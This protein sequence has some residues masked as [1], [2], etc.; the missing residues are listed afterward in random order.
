ME[1]RDFKGIEHRE[2]RFPDRGILV[3]EGPNEVG[4]TSMIEALDLLLDHKDTSRRAEI[5]AARPIGRDVGPFVEVEMSTGPYRFTYRKRWLRRSLTELDVTAPTREQ[6]VG[7]VAHERVRALLAQTADLHLWRALRLMQASP[8]D[9]AELSGSPALAAALDRAAG[10]A[11]APGGEGDTILAAA[12]EVYLRYFT[13]KSGQPTGEYRVLGERLERA[14]AAVAA[15]QAGLDEVAADVDRHARLQAEITECARQETAA[16]AALDQVEA[17]WADVEDVVA[18]A[19]RARRAHDDARRDHDLAI[20]RAQERARAVRDLAER[21]LA[22]AGARSTLDE[23]RERLAPDDAAAAGRAAELDAAVAAEARTRADLV[24]A[25]A[26]AE[27]A[28]EAEELREVEA[29]L[30][31]IDRA[32][33]DLHAA[34]AAAD[35]APVDAAALRRVEDAAR[36]LAVARAREDAVSARVSVRRLDGHPV[37][38]VD[39]SPLILDAPWERALSEPVTLVVGGEVEIALAPD[40]AASRLAAGVAQAREALDD[41]LVRAGVDSLDAA[42]A[43]HDVRRDREE[44]VRSARDALAALLSGDN[45]DDLAA[46]RDRLRERPA[47]NAENAEST[48]GAD[49]VESTAPTEP[50]EAGLTRAREAHDAARDEVERVRDAHHAAR[51]SGH[52]ARIELARAESLAEAVAAETA[53]LSARLAAAREACADADLESARESAAA[54]AEEA[55]REAGRHEQRVREADVDALRTQLESARAEVPGVLRRRRE[56]EDDRLRVAARLEHA[57]G[58][59]R[60]E[61]FDA[62]RSEHAHVTRLFEATTRHAQAARL[63]RTLLRDESDAARRAY[64]RPFTDAITRLGRVVYGASFDV[65]VAD[66]LSVTS[67]TVDGRAVPFA[68]LSSGAKEQLAILTRLACASVVDAEHGVPVLI[69]DALGYSDPDKLRRVCAA[70]GR[71]DPGAQVVLLTCTPGRYS[72]IG[73][74]DVVRL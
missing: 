15:A 22:L 8:L 41:A 25:R 70:F 52:E 58:Q 1:I 64:V 40:E 29:R 57:G 37:V 36:D 35:E 69:D 4:K 34:R 18:A 26:R 59:G 17:H 12:E 72:A 38:E 43:A 48:E 19:Q 55:S 20:G 61:A 73:H 14:E 31:R 60:R 13:A 67:R 50:P 44:D 21:E 10:A 71:L 63:L 33:A 66:D 47:E 32:S 7:D 65:E 9:P 24:A 2:L 56:L 46:A 16:R 62:A 27:H 51:E 42:R 23:L 28:R 3:V 6:L 39:G 30:D 54:R 49:D 53:G 74:A 68:H 11:N 5:R 45:R